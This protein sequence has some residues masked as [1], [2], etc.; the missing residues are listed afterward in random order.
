MDLLA[1]TKQTVASCLPQQDSLAHARLRRMMPG[2]HPA[3]QHRDPALRQIP[4]GEFM[5]P[6]TGSLQGSLWA[7][8]GTGFFPPEV[9]QV[10]QFQASCSLLLNYQK[11]KRHMCGFPNSQPDTQPAV[12]AGCPALKLPGLP[13]CTQQCCGTH[14]PCKGQTCDSGTGCNRPK[15]GEMI[16]KMAPVTSVK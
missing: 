15:P 4:A 6:L 12:L 10:A 11:G 7:I 13:S 2:A 1:Q 9:H 8:Q 3:L 14:I 16:S 5:L